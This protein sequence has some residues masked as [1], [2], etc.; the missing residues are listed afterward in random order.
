MKPIRGKR[1]LLWVLLILAFLATA[2]AAYVSLLYLEG[3]VSNYTPP[4]PPSVSSLE[5]ARADLQHLAQAV[6]AY[7]IQH[8]EYPEKIENLLPEFLDRVANDPLSGKPY[9]YTLSEADGSSR[10]RIS[11]PDP[12]LYHVKELCIEDGKLVEN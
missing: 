1:R 11:V 12:G 3:D 8:M 9:L 4:Q 6:D 10:Y 2:I 7:F 5:Q